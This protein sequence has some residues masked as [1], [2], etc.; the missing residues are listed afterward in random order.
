MYAENSWATVVFRVG[1]KSHLL[2]VVIERILN[3]LTPASVEK[4]MKRSAKGLPRHPE[5]GIPRND[6]NT[7][8]SYNIIYALPFA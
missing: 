4:Q 1:G 2:L 8:V 6:K 5:Y 3:Y 7:E